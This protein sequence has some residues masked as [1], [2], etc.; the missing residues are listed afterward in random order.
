L[1]KGFI[2]HGLNLCVFLFGSLNKNG[3]WRMCVGSRAINKIIVKYKFSI[4]R[5]EDMLD[6]LS[7]VK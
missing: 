5:L 7:S 4:S 1:K 2:R 6:E 3:F